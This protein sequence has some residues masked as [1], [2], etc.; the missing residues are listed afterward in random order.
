MPNNDIERGLIWQRGEEAR[1]N[2][3]FLN[4]RKTEIEW[5]IT[6]NLLLPS[7]YPFL[8]AIG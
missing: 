6:S 8:A 4:K 1:G 7:Y 3:Y 5:K 2:C